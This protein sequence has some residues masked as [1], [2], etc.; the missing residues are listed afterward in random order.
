MKVGSF[1]DGLW[2]L[3]FRRNSGGEATKNLSFFLPSRLEK[4]VNKLASQESVL[5][6]TCREK[7]YNKPLK[8]LRRLR[9]MIVES[10]LD[11]SYSL[12]FMKNSGSEATKKLSLFLA[13]R[14][15]KSENIVTSQESVS[16]KPRN[17]K[18]EKN[19]PKKISF[20]N[21]KESSSYESGKLS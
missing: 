19:T 20:K 7:Q 10:F 1:L 3:F 2:S 13:S 6:K 5:K 14:L 11:G 15:E 8:M 9:R 4:S 18:K 17:K 16:K 21:I 12:V